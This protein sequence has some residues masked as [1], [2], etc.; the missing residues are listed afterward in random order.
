MRYPGHSNSEREQNGV[1][2]VLGERDGR[3]RSYSLIGTKLQFWMLKKVLE[4]NGGS[5]YTKMWMY[6]MALHCTLKIVNMSNVVICIFTS[7]LKKEMQC[8]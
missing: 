4:M 8:Y 6:L 1:F 2:Q 7:I 3:M 5:D